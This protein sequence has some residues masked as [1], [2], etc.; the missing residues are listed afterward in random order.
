MAIAC[1]LREVKDL[2]TTSCMRLLVIEELSAVDGAPVIDEMEGLASRRALAAATL[3][4]AAAAVRAA[5][6]IAM[7]SST[8]SITTPALS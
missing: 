4:A 6:W 5:T 2:G 8:V 3:I 7:A 1:S